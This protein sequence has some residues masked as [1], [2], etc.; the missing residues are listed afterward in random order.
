M[1]VSYSKSVLV[2]VET[3]ALKVVSLV[4]SKVSFCMLLM[5]AVRPVKDASAVR[6]GAYRERFDPIT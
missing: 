3:I 5:E 2:C 1:D 4:A 6:I